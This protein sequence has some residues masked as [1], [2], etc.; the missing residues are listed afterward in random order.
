[1]DITKLDIKELK[2]LAY[3]LMAES[4]IINQNLSVV[5]KQ[6]EVLLAT[7]IKEKPIIN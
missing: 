1:M 3:D 6:I 2:A 4:Q 7:P 5:N